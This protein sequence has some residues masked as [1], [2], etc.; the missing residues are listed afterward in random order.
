ML[1]LLLL[2]ASDAFAFDICELL[3]K[4]EKVGEHLVVIREALGIHDVYL[5]DDSK[6]YDMRNPKKL[7]TNTLVDYGEIYFNPSNS[8]IAFLD[9]KTGNS[10]SLTYRI[11]IYNMDK[12]TLKT[13]V[14]SKIGQIYQVKWVDNSNLEYSYEHPRYKNMK[15]HKGWFKLKID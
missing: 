15:T 13:G 3:G 2:K 14:D 12:R 4:K 5:C 8:I 9:F 7:L 6:L 11:M 10:S 1:L